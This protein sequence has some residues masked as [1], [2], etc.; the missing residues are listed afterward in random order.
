MADGFDSFLQQASAQLGGLGNLGSSTMSMAS[1]GLSTIGTGI[2][3]TPGYLSTLSQQAFQPRPDLAM[4]RAPTSSNINLPSASPQPSGG[5]GSGLDFSGIFG[6]GQ[7]MKSQPSPNPIS[8]FGSWLSGAG[9]SIDRFLGGTGGTQ[10][11]LPSLSQVKQQDQPLYT[12]GT[13]AWTNKQ[14]TQ[15]STMVS[16]IRPDTAGSLSVGKVDMTLPA[17]GTTSVFMGEGRGQR[18]IQNAKVVVDEQGGSFGVYTTRPAREGFTPV[19]GFQVAG[20]SQGAAQSGQFSTK[21]LTP[22]IYNQWNQELAPTANKEEAA[23]VLANPELYSRLGAEAYGGKVQLLDKRKL[24]ISDMMGRYAPES[25]NLANLVNP[26][27][28]NLSKTEMAN[29]KIPWQID[30]KGDQAITTVT[31]SKPSDSIFTNLNMPTP[32]GPKVTM[33]SLFGTQKPPEFLTTWE[34]KNPLPKN[35]DGT[36]IP[37]LDREKVYTQTVNPAYTEFMKTYVPPQY[38]AVKEPVGPKPDTGFDYREVKMVSKINPE[39]EAYQ[40]KKVTPSVTIPEI[41][42]PTIVTPKQQVSSEF[43]LPEDVISVNA[44]TPSAPGKSVGENI[45]GW[46]D[47]VFIGTRLPETSKTASKTPEFAL[48]PRA[49][50]REEKDATFIGGGTPVKTPSVVPV[51]TGIITP[52]STGII[53]PTVSTVPLSTSVKQYV[54][55]AVFQQH[56]SLIS[57]ANK[58]RTT[59]LV[60]ARNEYLAAGGVAYDE[61]KNPITKVD[62]SNIDKQFNYQQ[63]SNT[64][65]SNAISKMIGTEA[66]INSKVADADA[67]APRMTEAKSASES[68]APVDKGLWENTNEWLG[69]NVTKKFVEEYPVA[70][71]RVIDALSTITGKGTKTELAK[72]GEATIGGSAFK[73]ISGEDQIRA[74]LSGDKGYMANVINPE[75][76]QPMQAMIKYGNRPTVDLTGWL[77]VPQAAGASFMGGRVEPGRKFS[78]VVPMKIEPVSAM[79]AF[80]NMPREKPLEAAM[81]YGTPIGLGAGEGL[82]SYLGVKGL[83]SSSPFIAKTA[84]IATQSPLIGTLYK[85]GSYALMGQMGAQEV[86]KIP[87]YSFDILAPLSGKSVISRTITGYTDAGKPIYAEQTPEATSA[88][89]GESSFGLVMMGLGGKQAGDISYKSNYQLPARPSYGSIERAEAGLSKILDVGLNP[90]QWKHAKSILSTPTPTTSIS[91][92]AVRSQAPGTI[93]VTRINQ[94]SEIGGGMTTT[95]AAAGKQGAT[96]KGGGAALEYKDFSKI[97]VGRD[98]LTKKINLELPAEKVG[99]TDLDINVDAGFGKAHKTFQEVGRAKAKQ[100][101][102]DL[103]STGM[104]ATVTAEPLYKDSWGIGRKYLDKL[105]DVKNPESFTGFRYNIKGKDSVTGIE[106]DTKLDQFIKADVKLRT[107]MS[108]V[109]EGSRISWW[110]TV[111][112]PAASKEIPFQGIGSMLFG[113]P[114]LKRESE[115]EYSPAKLMGKRDLAEGEIKISSPS[116]KVR[117]QL[118]N[119]QTAAQTGD[120]DSAGKSAW[121]VKTR[122]T[123]VELSIKSDI[124]KIN[125]DLTAGKITKVQADAQLKPL[126]RELKEVQTFSKDFDTNWLD[127][128]FYGRLTPKGPMEKINLRKQAQLAAEENAAKWDELVFPSIKPRVTSQPPVKPTTVKSPG[129][130]TSVIAKYPSLA[131]IISQPSTGGKSSSGKSASSITSAVS[132]YAVSL[133]SS[134]SSKPSA[135]SIPSPSPVS[136][137]SFV[138]SI[139][140]PISKSPESKS[141]SSPSSPSSSYS[142]LSSI[143]SMSSISS[144]SASPSSPSSSASSMGSKSSYSGGSAFGAPFLAP[145]GGGGGGGGGRGH[146]SGV[147]KNPLAELRVASA[148][149]FKGM[150]DY[151]LPNKLAADVSKNLK[152][153]QPY[154]TTGA[155]GAFSR[156]ASSSLQ[157]AMSIG[158]PQ[159]FIP[160]KIA[161]RKVKKSKPK[162]KSKSGKKKGTYK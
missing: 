97:E 33:T 39:W 142:S 15:P 66:V 122:I 70:G 151:R 153:T 16:N 14:V 127:A 76:G 34:Y 161:S 103:K 9:S 23:K 119:L 130:P 129:I 36:D 74:Y 138:S 59:T 46:L 64:A 5:F 28:A 1:S 3:N 128:E 152:Q 58:L 42:T 80:W 73:S 154:G 137:S 77:D 107:P 158:T 134:I 114:A 102:M 71:G 54:P 49:G 96:L 44:G 147:I 69:T 112:Q 4:Q 78:D 81:Y 52:P 94:P 148:K 22:V 11:Q 62:A 95:L 6:S 20:G 121:G 160:S 150:F 83:A 87:G 145:G 133:P 47:S 162:L 109:G 13:P 24:G 124:A 111:R 57:D 116:I 72:P 144:P 140:S 117:D 2:S 99:T 85:G 45:R 35:Y 106:T 104:D 8:G 146:L 17:P 18:E 21:A 156:G 29:E 143:S 26:F 25:G 89:F 126:N 60:S 63:P 41:T 10:Q 38:I 61:N 75:T 113:R 67:L 110:G 31:P 136:K 120:F 7:P 79:N 101:E 157:E 123:D 108:P 40:A 84:Q 100:L 90:S 53:S 91:S 82:I 92:G 86:T 50:A 118:D 19:Y 132:K 141:P 48:I 27:G 159:S 93:D 139:G 65:Q 32:V 30:W 125:T 155:S 43:M 131:G 51:S 98:P 56:E 115:Y 135:P 55:D 37:A 12:S 68:T 149:A 105:L 88:R